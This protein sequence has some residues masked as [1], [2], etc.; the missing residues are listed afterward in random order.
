MI[1]VGTDKADLLKHSNKFVSLIGLDEHSWGLS[2]LG[3]KQHKGLSY[4]YTKT[5]GQH[6]VV[7]MYCEQKLCMKSV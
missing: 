1:G 4:E 5:F 2:Y 3:T 7:G 6:T